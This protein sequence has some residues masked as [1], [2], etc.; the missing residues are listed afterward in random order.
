MPTTKWSTTN[1]KNHPA[2]RGYPR[3]AQG[4]FVIIG[5]P[6]VRRRKFAQFSGES[7]PFPEKIKINNPEKW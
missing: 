3:S 7:A 6:A 2:E 4:V 5:R 1:S